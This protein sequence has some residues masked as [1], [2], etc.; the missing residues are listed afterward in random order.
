MV[1]RRITYRT[2]RRSVDPH[3]SVVVAQRSIDLSP[4]CRYRRRCLARDTPTENG[5]CRHW[6][7][8]EWAEVLLQQPGPM[9]STD[10]AGLRA[11]NWRTHPWLC[12]RRTL[13][14]S[15]R[16]ET[17]PWQRQCLYQRTTNNIIINNRLNFSHSNRDK[18]PVT[19]E[20]EPVVLHWLE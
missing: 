2:T 9:T 15:F 11:E 10:A 1:N 4:C 3:S 8:A 16:Y 20:K 13:W 7:P 17:S 18:N 6:W 5:C 14:K 12:R 19:A